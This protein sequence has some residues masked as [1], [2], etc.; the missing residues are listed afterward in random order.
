MANTVVLYAPQLEALAKELVAKTGA[1]SLLST[2][3]LASC[4]ADDQSGSNSVALFW[5]TFPSAS[6]ELDPN[7]KVLHTALVGKH[8]VLLLSQDDTTSA[9]AQ[10]SLV[11]WLQRFVVPNPTKEHAD[12]K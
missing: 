1:A 4:G 6:T 9:F 2:A 8:V 12:G 10:L 3:D 11:L 7:T 5:D